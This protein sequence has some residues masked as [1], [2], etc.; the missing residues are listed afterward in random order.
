MLLLL[1][2]WAGLVPA[3]ALRCVP[4]ILLAL[5]LLLLHLARTPWHACQVCCAHDPF[6]PLLCVFVLRPSPPPAVCIP[7]FGRATP[8]SPCTIC[9]QGS[10][11]PGR[12]TTCQL[13]PNATFYP[14]VD[15]VG[16]T[17]TSVGTTTFLGAVGEE[18]CVPKESQLSPEAGQAFF[19]SAPAVQALL[20]TTNATSLATCLASCEPTA[21]CMVQWHADT[22]KCK[23]ASLPPVGADALGFKLLYKLPPSTMGSASSIK[24]ATAAAPE[25][26]GVTAKTISSGI[27]ARAA[28]PDATKASWLLVGTNL[29]QM[30]RTFSKAD[31]ASLWRVGSEAECKSLCDNSNVC[32][33]F[34]HDGSSCLF[35]GGE[36]AL[37]T[38]SFMVLPSGDVSAFNWQGASALDLAIRDTLSLA[39][40]QGVTVTR[41]QVVDALNAVAAQNGGTYSPA[42][43]LQR[44]QQQQ[45]AD[46]A[47]A[48]AAAAALKAAVEEVVKMGAEQGYTIDAAVAEK[49][50]VA[51]G[52]PYDTQAALATIVASM[53]GG[54]GG[55]SGGAALGDLVSKLREVSSGQ[56]VLAPMWQQAVAVLL[57]TSP[58]QPDEWD[59]D[60]AFKLWLYVVS[61]SVL[62]VVLEKMGPQGVTAQEAVNAILAVPDLWK[63]VQAGELDGVVDLSL[64]RLNQQGKATQDVLVAVLKGQTSSPMFASQ[65]LVWDVVNMTFAAGPVDV[66]IV[67]EQLGKLREVADKVLSVLKEPNPEV[68]KVFDQ[69]QEQLLWAV[70]MAAADSNGDWDAAVQLSI[71]RL[72]EVLEIAKALV[73]EV[74]KALD[75]YAMSDMQAIEFVLLGMAYSRTIYKDLVFAHVP[76]IAE[77]TKQLMK[78]SGAAVGEAFS[79]WSAASGQVGAAG[80]DN[81]AGLVQVAQQQLQL[82]T[83]VQKKA[84]EVFAANGYTADLEEVNAAV[85]GLYRRSGYWTFGDAETAAATAWIELAHKLG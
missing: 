23:R 26:G 58:K 64:E 82:A 10:Y 11:Q 59:V 22:S 50:L 53:G 40:A 63:R 21:C 78:A 84:Q 42:Q 65:Q 73:P 48:A 4:C 19:G 27:Y 14:P 15:G 28:I 35:R 44:I 55:G 77:G 56:Q 52:A 17:W 49:V 66:G 24:A 72:P 36:D 57:M 76:V 20:T 62:K 31:Q 85:V 29:D 69:L 7:G 45:A 33:G 61:D 81:I 1:W 9:P 5:L 79:A 13:C 34:I 54:G 47:A 67:A 8:S 3:Q 6:S 83:D 68:Y 46:A 41:Q 38:R 12:L 16:A 60:A 51:Q 74:S 18:S 32:W 2:S 80:S 25:A 37:K 70:S 43:A 30:G 75:S 71:Q 39:A